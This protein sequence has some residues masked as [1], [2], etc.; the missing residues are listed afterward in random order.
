VGV[1]DGS[2][3]S[4]QATQESPIPRAKGKTADIFRITQGNFRTTTQGVADT[5]RMG[6]N[7]AERRAPI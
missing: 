2:R 3:I 7:T 5:P 1:S 4:A 6:R